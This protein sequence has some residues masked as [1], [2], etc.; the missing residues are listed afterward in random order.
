M[1]LVSAQS[2]TRE[3]GRD[4]STTVDRYLQTVEDNAYNSHASLRAL[5]QAPGVLGTHRGGYRVH[6]PL[7]LTS[8]DKADAVAKFG[9]FNTDPNKTR[10]AALYSLS[11]YISPIT[12]ENLDILLTR[13]PEGIAPILQLETDS[14]RKDMEKR[15]NLDIS[16]DASANSERIIGL[17]EITTEA[18]TLGTLGGVSRVNN[19]TYRSNVV[20]NNTLSNLIADM[21]NA[22]TS[23]EDGQDMP[24]LI[25]CGR[26]ARRRYVSQLTG[27]IR[28]DPLEIAKGGPADAS[29]RDLLFGGARLVTDADFQTWGGGTG[30]VMSFINTAYFHLDVAQSFAS[31]EFTRPSSEDTMKGGIR[32]VGALYCTRLNR[33]SLVYDIQAS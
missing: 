25:L 16:D 5:T 2:D 7:E 19:S 24:N 1:A 22:Y 28:V 13:D 4:F 9:T 10:T 26:T 30:V 8:P 3:L 33:Q 11:R 21:E 32:W 20:Q 31:M 12:V 15:I 29:M 18:P 17:E 6:V 14:A 23:A 27:T